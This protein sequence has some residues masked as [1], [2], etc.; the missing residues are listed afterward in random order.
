MLLLKMK[1]AWLGVKIACLQVLYN[2]ID[3]LRA[4]DNGSPER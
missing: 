3:R 1:T 2:H 4:H